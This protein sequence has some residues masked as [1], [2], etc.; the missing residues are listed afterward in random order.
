MKV[1]LYTSSENNSIGTIRLLLEQLSVNYTINP[2]DTTGFDYA[3]SYGGDGTFLSSVRKMGHGFIPIL[4]INSGRLGFLSTVTK[5]H[6]GQAIE[7]LIAGDFDL[8][9]RTLIKVIA[10]TMPEGIPT[11][12]LNE[13]S[14]QKSGTGMVMIEISIDGQK[15][16]NYWADGIIISTPT[17]S[18]AYSM[19][20][21]G[22]ILTPTCRNFI[23][24]PIAPHNLNIRPLVIPDTASVSLRVTTRLANEAIATMDNR[25][26]KV[27]S[28]TSFEIVRSKYELETIKLHD[29]SFYQTIRAKLL[30]GIDP[31]D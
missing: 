5:E 22:A 2:K 7:Q 11:R 27:V 6:A 26:Y 31:R 20:V 23:I 14:I 17:G 16:G 25:E 18:T 21:G 28:G 10:D 24:S 30:W 8:E 13:F 3:L 9:R 1:A 15:V 12:A 29:S 19:S 4:G